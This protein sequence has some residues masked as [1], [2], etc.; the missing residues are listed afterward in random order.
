VLLAPT[1]TMLA[2]LNHLT[3]AVTDLQR[4]VDFYVRV[5]GFR[6]R[7]QWDMGAYLELG[8]LWLCLSSDEQRGQARSSD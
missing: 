8:D 7:A 2:G 5:L 1:A 6:P 4:S 3:L